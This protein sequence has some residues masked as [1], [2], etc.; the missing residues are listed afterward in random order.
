MSLVL[1][2]NNLDIGLPWNL[3]LG[4]LP[5]FVFQIHFKIPTDC[6]FLPLFSF[7]FFLG[8]FVCFW[9]YVS[10]LSLPWYSRIWRPWAFRE[11]W[12]L[13]K[14]C[15]KRVLLELNR[16]RG[17]HNSWGFLV[18]GSRHFTRIPQ[19]PFHPDTSPAISPRYLSRR[20][21][22]PKSHFLWMS[23]SRHYILSTPTPNISQPPC[24]PDTSAAIPPGYFNRHF[25]RMPQPPVHPDTSAAISPGYLNCSS[26]QPKVHFLRMSHSH[27]YILPTP[28]PDISQPPC[29]PDTPAAISPGYLSRHSIQPTFPLL[30][31]L[32]TRMSHSRHATQIPQPPFHLDTSA[33]IL[34]GRSHSR[35]SIQPTFRLLRILHTRMSQSHHA[36]R[37]HQLPFHPDTSAA[38]LSGRHPTSTRMSHSRHYTRPISQPPFYLIDPTAAILLSRSHSRLSTRPISQPS[39]HP[40]YLIAAILSVRRS[41]FSGYFTPGAWRWMG[42]GAIQLP[43]SDLSR[44]ANGAYLESVRSRQFK[45]PGQLGSS[46]TCD[47]PNPFPPRIKKQIPIILTTKSPELSLIFNVR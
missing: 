3:M 44:S 42:K 23:H 37:I 45:F 24:H 28:T 22:Q 21:T 30:R 34:H 2:E 7:L 16:C 36:T 41:V 27:H 18:C 1:S 47:S 26:T 6:L 31:I 20:S 19:P 32:H 4:V 12:E 5:L 17:Y 25:T 33:A 11:R 40:A 46:D 38:I 43:P 15:V 35:H 29:H 14:G 13:D 9:I 39:F 10:P 8:L